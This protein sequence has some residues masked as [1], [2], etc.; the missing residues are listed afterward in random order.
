VARREL[1]GPLL[2][3]PVF[4]R[5]GVFFWC[6][7]F[8]VRLRYTFLLVSLVIAATGRRSVPEVL[9]WLVALTLGVLLHELGHALMARHYGGQPVIELHTMGGETSWTWTRSPRWTWLIACSLAGPG[10]GIAFGF[11]LGHLAPLIPPTG[12]MY[13]LRLFVHDLHWVTF[14]WSFVNLLPILPLDGA[15]ALEAFLAHHW[16]PERARHRMR[17]LSVV[18][19][20]VAVVVAISLAMPWAALLAGLFAYNNAQALR[21]MPGFRIRG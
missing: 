18:T 8:I 4:S 14:G 2:S 1:G 15:Q 20:I 9:V 6:G 13:W 16:G 3:L 7:G 11:L 21:G 10:I 5:N 17:I 19:G 12:A